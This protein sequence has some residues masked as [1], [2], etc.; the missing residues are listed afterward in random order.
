M[1][2]SD[3][4]FIV[5]V[6]ALSGAIGLAIKYLGPRLPLDPSLGLAAVLLLGPSLLM[7]SLLWAWAV[8]RP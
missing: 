5:K 4:I 2:R 6:I 7:A 3:L 8:S 1:Q